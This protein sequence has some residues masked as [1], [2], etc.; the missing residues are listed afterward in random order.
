MGG[1]DQ[2]QALCAISLPTHHN[3][4]FARICAHMPPPARSLSIQ[5][6]MNACGGRNPTS[7]LIICS[8][9]FKTL[10]VAFADHVRVAH[11][12]HVLLHPSFAAFD[13]LRLST[14]RHQS[15]LTSPFL[16]QRKVVPVEPRVPLRTLVH[17]CST[18]KSLGARY[19]PGLKAEVLF[20]SHE[21][22]RCS[23]LMK[24]RASQ[25]RSSALKIPATLIRS[26]TLGQTSP[27]TRVPV[28][29][30]RF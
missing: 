14:P 1:G 22:Y 5:A 3:S 27:L 8:K 9:P 7:L 15:L 29:L 19:E 25:L 20:E 17:V 11:E 24:N 28:S 26:S 18:P 16:G 10:A 6:V 2:G 23:G 4:K 30:K 13:R 12:Q 21:S